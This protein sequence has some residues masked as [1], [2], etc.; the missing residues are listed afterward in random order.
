M[1]LEKAKPDK[2]FNYAFDNE[3]PLILWLAED[4]LKA[5]EV[6]VKVCFHIFRFFTREKSTPSNAIIC[7]K[8]SDLLLNASGRISWL[9]RSASRI[10]QKRERNDVTW[11]YVKYIR[12]FFVLGCHSLYSPPARD[13]LY[14]FLHDRFLNDC[15]S[16]WRCHLGCPD[17][18]KAINVL[19]LSFFLL[20]FL[21]E[22]QD[23]RMVV[24]LFVDLFHLLVVIPHLLLQL[25]DGL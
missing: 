3:I 16:D 17:G 4:E 2:Q 11:K 25:S 13:R 15:F 9:G 12:S 18:F 24:K 22:G 7:L 6:K 19:D 21:V 5:G 23:L 14:R 1:Y 10:L 20:D 8:T